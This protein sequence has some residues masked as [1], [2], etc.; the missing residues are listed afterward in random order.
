MREEEWRAA[1][2]T[3]Q[4]REAL[5]NPTRTGAVISRCLLPVCDEGLV[6]SRGPHH[7]LPSCSLQR[8][9]QQRG[10]LSSGAGDE[11]GCGIRGAGSRFVTTRQRLGELQD[12]GLDTISRLN[13]SPQPRT[14]SEENEFL[15]IPPW[16]PLQSLPSQPRGLDL[17][18]QVTKPT[19]RP[20]GPRPFH[21]G[22]KTL[23]SPILLV[24]M[25]A[26]MKNLPQTA[27][28]L[29]PMFP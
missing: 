20:A 13:S 19:H 2:S 25:T 17:M 21:D 8:L 28:T 5:Q 27:P 7:W 12:T 22:H 11:C 3:F 29:A 9:W 10:P 6:P 14:V 26:H 23:P 1:K 16:R 18:P 15:C 4:Q 24:K